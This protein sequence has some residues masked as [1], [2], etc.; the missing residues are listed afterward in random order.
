MSVKAC[1]RYA[2]C[3][4]LDVGRFLYA[5]AGRQVVHAIHAIIDRIEAPT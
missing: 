3:H 5:F 2:F 1:S 4:C